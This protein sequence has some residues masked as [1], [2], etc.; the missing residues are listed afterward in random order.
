MKAE[1]WSSLSNLKKRVELIESKPGVILDKDLSLVYSFAS[2]VSSKEYLGGFIMGVVLFGSVMRDEATKSSDIDVLVLVDDVTNEITSEMAGAYS[3]T[4]AS[5]L[6]K[7]NAQNKIHVTTLGLVRFWD[8]VRNGDP[9]V[10]SIIR[11]GKPIVDT[12]FFNPLKALLERGLIKPSREAIIANLRMAES[13]LRNQSNFLTRCV[14]DSYWAV[15]DA[16]HSL[17]MHAGLETTHPRDVSRVFREAAGIVGID[18]SLSGVIDLFIKILGDVK[19]GKRFSGKRVDE[20]RRE[21]ERFV[22]A[23]K[24]VVD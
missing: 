15:I 19:A 22:K 4:I 5:I 10:M 17:I 14:V 6:A 23:V 9:I 21:A 13:L 18:S 7:L 24:I 1:H 8:G 12:G 16:A 3:L 11:N 20:L 2:K